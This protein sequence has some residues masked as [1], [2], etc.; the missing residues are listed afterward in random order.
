[1]EKK[2]S[3]IYLFLIYFCLSSLYFYFSFICSMLWLCSVQIQFTLIYSSGFFIF[4]ICIFMYLICMFFNFLSTL[5]YWFLLKMFNF[6]FFCVNWINNL[7]LCFVVALWIRI[8]YRFERKGNILIVYL[9]CLFPKFEIN[10]GNS[11]E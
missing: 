8:A 7:D 3:I 5:F 9:E 11:V 10:K 6:F 2:C 1:M 4:I